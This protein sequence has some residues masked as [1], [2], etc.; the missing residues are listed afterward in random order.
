ML[1][2]LFAI[3]QLLLK[4]KA[5]HFKTFSIL[6]LQ[7]TITKQIFTLHKFFLYFLFLFFWC[8]LIIFLLQT[9]TP[10]IPVRA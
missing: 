5:K 9:H 1:S 2:L 6:H 10:R 7:F 3:E 4:I 8:F